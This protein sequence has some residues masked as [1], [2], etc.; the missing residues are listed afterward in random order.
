LLT[1]ID[2]TK[3]DIYT[4]LITE[5]CRSVGFLCKPSKIAALLLSTKLDRFI[6]QQGTSL[7]RDD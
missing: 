5:V 1:K 7:D 4:V 6:C 2:P 3:V